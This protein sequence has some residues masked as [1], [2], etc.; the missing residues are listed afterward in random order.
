MS[1][2][3]VKKRV[4]TAVCVVL[5]VIIGL[6]FLPVFVYAAIVMFLIGIGL[7]EFYTLIEKKGIFLYKSLGIFIGLLIPLSVYSRLGLSA[8]WELFF[9]AICVLIFFILYL[10]RKDNSQA[11]IGISTSLFG[12]FYVSCFFSFLIKIRLLPQGV[13]LA[14]FLLLITKIGDIGAYI[15]GT[16]LGRNSFFSK[17]SPKKTLEGAF[18]GLLF[19]LIA[20]LLSKLYLGHIPLIH[21]FF[22]GLLIAIVAQLGD[23]C[24]SLI[25]RDCAVK[26]SGK[27]FPGLGGVLDII[28]SIIFTAPIFYYYLSYFDLIL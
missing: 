27:Y 13:F 8:E 15:I 21:L 17:I 20:A 18:G 12:I 19:S 23:L 10:T 26:D 11:I 4:I 5:I 6:F 25:K 7:Y 1:E 2:I 28:D 24:E 3:A 9:A 22:M 16:N 14:A